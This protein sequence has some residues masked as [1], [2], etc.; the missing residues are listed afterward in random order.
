MKHNM[1]LDDCSDLQN[2]LKGKH[3]SLR[4]GWVGERDDHGL[5]EFT[6]IFCFALRSKRHWHVDPGAVSISGYEQKRVC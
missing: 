1:S 6:N 5:R 3:F 2:T 4:I